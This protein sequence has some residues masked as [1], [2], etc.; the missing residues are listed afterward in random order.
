M[1]LLV[2]FLLVL[3]FV[4]IF[5]LNYSI[6]DDSDKKIPFLDVKSRSQDLAKS[7]GICF[8]W[9]KTNHK[10][11]KVNTT[12]KTEIEYIYIYFIEFYFD[13]A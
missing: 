11:K 6:S 9:T 7:S 8:V 2:L 10:K 1:F 4:F 13:L 5:Y 12:R 3:W